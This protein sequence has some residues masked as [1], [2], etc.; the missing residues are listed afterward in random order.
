MFPP[1]AQ[2]GQAVCGFLE[3][4]SETQSVLIMPLCLI[5]TVKLKRRLS[6]ARMKNVYLG[7]IRD[8][9]NNPVRVLDGFFVPSQLEK[10][11]SP[12][13]ISTG[14]TGSASTAKR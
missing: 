6:H 8:K 11:V 2:F 1:R 10:K 3:I 5:Q 12:L 14:K 9:G 7:M 13:G 4:R